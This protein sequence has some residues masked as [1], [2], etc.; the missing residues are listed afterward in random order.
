MQ[1]ITIVQRIIQQPLMAV[2]GLLAGA[3]AAKGGH[4]DWAA[5]GILGYFAT[6]LTFMGTRSVSARVARTQRAQQT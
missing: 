6:T 3:A 2:L 4:G 1:S 5:I